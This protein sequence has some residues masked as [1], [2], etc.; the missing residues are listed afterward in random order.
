MNVTSFNNT[1]G[2][3]LTRECHRKMFRA[4]CFQALLPLPYFKLI[5]NVVTS[6]LPFTDVEK[7]SSKQRWPFC[8]IMTV[9]LDRAGLRS[10]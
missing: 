6:Y 1:T 9:E 2:I 7:L 10:E 8:I 3:L 4:T 5:L